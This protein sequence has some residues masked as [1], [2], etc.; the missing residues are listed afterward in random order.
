MPTATN[1][2]VPTATLVPTPSVDPAL[3]GYSPLL[4][5]AVS[6]YTDR[7]GFVSGS[8]TA[9]E[10]NILDWADSRVFSNPAF[11]A[12]KYSPNNWPSPVKN[13]SVRAFLELMKEI[14]VQ[15]KSNGKHVIN[16][17]V[18]SLDRIL[19]GLGVYE[20][21]CTSCYG[22]NDYNTKEEVRKNYMP[23]VT[24]QGHIHREMLKTFAYFAKADGEGILIRSFMENDADDFEMLYK[25]DPSRLKG[26]NFYTHASFGWRNQSFMSQMTLPDETVESFPTMVYER[27]GGAKTPREAAERWFGSINRDLKHFTGGTEDFADIYR[28]Y[29]Q[30]P[31]TPEP[32]YILIV[33]EAGSP[34]STGLTVSAFNLIGLKAEQF[35]SPENGYRTGGVEIDGEWFYHNGNQPLGT[36]GGKKDKPMCLF[37]APLQVVENRTWDDYCGFKGEIDTGSSNSAEITGGTSGGFNIFAVSFETGR[38]YRIRAKGSVAGGGTLSKIVIALCS[39]GSLAHHECKLISDKTGMGADPEIIYSANMDGKHY[40]FLSGEG[41]ET[42]TYTLEV[43][44]SSP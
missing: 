35:L 25:R 14:D 28:P 6:G 20:G 19:D 39:N 29:S 23:I 32:G 11:L 37:L 41:A 9:E 15:K 17:G 43:E 18:D 21:I 5:E 27:I 31:Y 2:P 12:S 30:T 26:R 22:K 8:L 16:W 38:S 4:V 13:D 7:P 24:D 36:L 3:A 42:G 34:S 1:T 33:G 40:L 10:K 44:Q